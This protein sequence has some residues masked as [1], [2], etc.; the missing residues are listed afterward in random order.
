MMRC[1]SETCLR[2]THGQFRCRECGAAICAFCDLK[3]RGQ[4]GC[5]N[6]GDDDWYSK[7]FGR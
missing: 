7:V 1:A 4:C 3:Y 2:E 6:R 5:I